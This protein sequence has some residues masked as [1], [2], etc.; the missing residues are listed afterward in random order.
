MIQGDGGRVVA[1]IEHLED[2]IQQSVCIEQTDIDHRG[3]NVVDPPGVIEFVD[4]TDE[5]PVGPVVAESH[6]LMEI[7]ESRDEQAV[8]TKIELLLVGKVELE[9]GFDYLT[10]ARVDIVRNVMSV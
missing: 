4:F 7:K 6:E 8:K 3:K 5:Y 9:P 10:G 1:K 2:Y